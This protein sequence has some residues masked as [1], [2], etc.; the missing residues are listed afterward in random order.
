MVGGCQRLAVTAGVCRSAGEEGGGRRGFLPAGREYESGGM[1]PP[2]LPEP[3]WGSGAKL[4]GV[5]VHTPSL[6]GRGAA[7]A[8]ALALGRGLTLM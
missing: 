3:P 6:M 2:S 4:A 1:E 5:G 8:M 7:E